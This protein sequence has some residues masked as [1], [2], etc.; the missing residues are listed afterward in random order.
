[1]QMWQSFDSIAIRR[2]YGQY[3]NALPITFFKETLIK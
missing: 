2:S 3:V 1:M